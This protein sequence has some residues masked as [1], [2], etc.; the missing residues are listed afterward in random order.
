MRQHEFTEEQYELIK[1]LMLANGRRGGQWKDH[2]TTLNGMF[3]VLH[4]D[5]QWRE[6]PERY[7]KWPSVYDRFNRWTRDGT[8]D[9]IFERFQFRLDEDPRIDW[10]LWCADG[11]NIR[12]SRSAADTGQKTMPTNPPTT[13]GVAREA[14]GEASY[15]WSLTVREF[16]SPSKHRPVN[17]TSHSGL[18]R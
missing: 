1:G 7:G 14:T 17:A 11:S 18:S 5:A 13:R 12:A 10:D 2:R 9:K 3:W 8:I 6:M 4:T 15:T 16:P